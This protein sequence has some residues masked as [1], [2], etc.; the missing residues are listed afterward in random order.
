MTCCSGDSGQFLAKNRAS[1]RNA[2]STHPPGLQVSDSGH[3]WQEAPVLRECP[4]N[5]EI[6]T[7]IHVYCAV[8]CDKFDEEKRVWYHEGPCLPDTVSCRTCKLLMRWWDNHNKASGTGGKI[9][10]PQQ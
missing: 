10:E 1:D 5:I 6:A 2:Q 7:D 8:V 3:K 9:A 4:H